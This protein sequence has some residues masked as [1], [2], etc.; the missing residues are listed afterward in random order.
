VQPTPHHRASVSPQLR[1]PHEL[2]DKNR[3]ITMVPSLASVWA[4]LNAIADALKL[5]R[6]QPGHLPTASQGGLYSTPSQGGAAAHVPSPGWGDRGAVAEALRDSLK[7]A[8]DSDRK[9]AAAAAAVRGS[10]GA[11]SRGFAVEKLPPF[12]IV[13]RARHVSMLF[14]NTCT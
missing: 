5:G 8:V 11:G 4:D 14:C 7:R 2:S 1:L 6:G 12:N 3:H 10:K 13:R 9:C